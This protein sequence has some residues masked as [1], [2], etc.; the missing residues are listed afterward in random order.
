MRWLSHV[1]YRYHTYSKTSGHQNDE[2]PAGAQACIVARYIGKADTVEE[3]RRRSPKSKLG[4]NSRD[5][6]FRKIASVPGSKPPKNRTETQPSR[7]LLGKCLRRVDA[8]R[9]VRRRR[10]QRSRRCVNRARGISRGGG[11]GAR[12][13]DKSGRE[14]FSETRSQ[15]IP[16]R[17]AKLQYKPRDLRLAVKSLQAENDYIYVQDFPFGGE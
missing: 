5:Q 4:E 10:S 16:G 7:N 1:A 14:S 8:R 12:P 17:G 3:Q 2:G 9:P 6:A 13:A 15:R 11:R